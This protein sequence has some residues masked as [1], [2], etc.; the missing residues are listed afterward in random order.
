MFMARPPVILLALS[1]LAACGRGPSRDDALAAIRAAQPGVEGSAV[2]GRVWQDGPPWFS[3]AEVKAKIATGVDSAV[4]RGQVRNWTDVV[5]VGWATPRDTSH[6]V[7][8][9]PGWCTLRLTPEGVASFSRWTTSAGPDF[10]TGQPR[11][12]WTTIVGRRA[13]V[14]NTSPRRDGDDAALAEYLVVVTPNAE[15]AAVGADKDTARWMARLVRADGRWRVASARPAP[16]PPRRAAG[17][18]T[19]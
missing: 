5:A 11:R 15:G 3:C 13:F 12:G 1:L 4:V 7:V 10:P 14:V 18:R 16:A 9:D 19:R 6:G 17:F 8:V 2:T